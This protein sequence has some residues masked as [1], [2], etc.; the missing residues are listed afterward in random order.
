[1]MGEKEIARELGMILKQ[2]EATDS[3]LSCLAE[4]GVNEM[5]VV[6]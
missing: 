1:M 5:A 4:D 3:L 2:E 6:E